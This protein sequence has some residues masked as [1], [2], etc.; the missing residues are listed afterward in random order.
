MGDAK[1][2]QDSLNLRAQNKSLNDEIS[3][4]KSEKND[5][6]KDIAALR[7]YASELQSHLEMTKKSHSDAVYD[8]RLSNELLRLRE[9]EANNRVTEIQSSIQVN[10]KDGEDVLQYNQCLYVDASRRR[11]TRSVSWKPT[12]STSLRSTRRWKGAR[13]LV[14]LTPRE[15]SKRKIENYLLYWTPWHRFGRV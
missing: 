1:T 11:M 10:D 12:Y 15:Q 14:S 7:D 6:I 9:L 13:P 5:A 2:S 3:Q 8:L 4:L